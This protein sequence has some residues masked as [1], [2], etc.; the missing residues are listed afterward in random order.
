MSQFLRDVVLH[1]VRVSA[2]QLRPFC[3]SLLLSMAQLPRHRRATLELLHSHLLELMS[4]VSHQ[5]DSLSLA[6]VIVAHSGL[7]PR[8]EQLLHSTA[9]NSQ[10]LESIQPYLVELAVSLLDTRCAARERG[11]VARIDRISFA[12]FSFDVQYSAATPQVNAVCLGAAVLHALFLSS[13][14]A[15][16][17]ILDQLQQRIARVGS[18]A[19]P[20]IALL[21]RLVERCPEAFKAQRQRV[22]DWVDGLVSL[23]SQ[24]AL[25]LLRAILRLC[26]SSQPQQAE[27]QDNIRSRLLMTLKKLMFAS[28][29]SA[30][31]LA[32]NGVVCLIE[33][34]L[35]GRLAGGSDEGGGSL[36]QSSQSSGPSIDVALLLELLS[37]LRRSLSSTV[38]VKQTL[39]GHLASL[40][41][42]YPL[43]R[44]H[45]VELLLPSFRYCQSEATTAVPFAVSQCV[46]GGCITEPLPQLVLCIVHALSTVGLGGEGA[47]AQ[48]FHN[49]RVT[50][51]E[52]AQ[53]MARLTQAQ[54]GV[55]RS[56][57]TP[58]T[59]VSRPLLMHGLYQAC[60]ELAVCGEQRGKADERQQSVDGDDFAL[61]RQL[62]D[63]F[64]LLDDWLTGR[65]KEG[66]MASGKDK[67]K[68]KGKGKSSQSKARKQREEKD[69]ED[70]TES[71]DD[72]AREAAG[73]RG[74]KQKAAAA[75][76][77]A[78][79]AER[80]SGRN[81]RIAVSHLLSPLAL[82]LILRRLLTVEY[83]E[84]VSS[85]CR[86]ST[87]A[88]ASSA[89]AVLLTELP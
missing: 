54:C 75:G 38:A 25:L 43:A 52:C 62:F 39:Y 18:S 74:S 47:S 70:E 50:L 8:V 29:P 6:P 21:H 12:T 63:R 44:P 64:L 53:R 7:Y 41:F 5:F 48:L 73:S 26:H 84:Y 58:E 69:E 59:D 17:F 77:K 30:R 85:H 67:G 31:L 78:G 88:A 66:Q 22:L 14:R 37:L 24:L 40:F 32:C 28:M 1:V 57:V 42:N 11:A 68:T 82:N 60:M 2:V 71:S 72:G 23:P 87:A 86:H 20:A 83:R 33:A 55:P 80:S 65:A 19:L 89:S 51:R 27:Q 45:I 3:L 10:Y 9:V 46:Y 16:S 61:F 49:M 56:A 34:V 36:S 79:K 4:A 13:P 35:Q 81:T 76:R 15:Q